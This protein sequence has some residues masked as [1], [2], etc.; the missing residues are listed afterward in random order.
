MSVTLQSLETVMGLIV[1]NLILHWFFVVKVEKLIKNQVDW[2][3]QARLYPSCQNVRLR[4]GVPDFLSPP[5]G[6]LRQESK[7]VFNDCVTVLIYYIMQID[8]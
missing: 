1:Y 2:W 8:Q 6:L 3:E 7:L 4:K 5:Q